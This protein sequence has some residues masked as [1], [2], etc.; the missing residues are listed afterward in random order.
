MGV[1]NAPLALSF[2]EHASRPAG[3]ALTLGLVRPPQVSQKE[4]LAPYGKYKGFY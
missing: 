1:D 3:R 4:R 2:C